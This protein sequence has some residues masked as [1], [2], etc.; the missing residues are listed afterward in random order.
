MAD[1]VSIDRPLQQL[2]DMEDNS[3]MVVKMFAD[4]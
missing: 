1:L 2:A 4:L 3:V